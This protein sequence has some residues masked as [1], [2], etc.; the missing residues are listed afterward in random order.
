M[1]ALLFPGQG[2]QEVGMGRDACEASPASQATKATAGKHAGPGGRRMCRPGSAG[3]AVVVTVSVPLPETRPLG[4]SCQC[5]NTG[6][7]LPESTAEPLLQVATDTAQA[8]EKLLPLLTKASGQIKQAT[9][10]L[11]LLGREVLRLSANEVE[12][13]LLRGVNKG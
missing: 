13:R 5:V 6:L 7:A 8:S 3:I 4:L 12:K 9:D 11:L 1:L 2:S 10:L